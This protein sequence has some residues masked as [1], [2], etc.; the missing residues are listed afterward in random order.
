LYEQLLRFSPQ[1]PLIL[2]SLSEVYATRATATGSPQ[3]S[4][5]A[6]DIARELYAKNPGNTMAIQCYAFRLFEI[7]N[8]KEAENLLAK[9]MVSD[10]ASPRVREIWRLSMENVIEGLEVSGETYR[11]SVLCSQL[12]LYFPQN[13]LALKYLR[14]DGALVPTPAI[15]DSGANDL[16]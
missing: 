12:L 5:K 8:Y 16:F 14:L 6:F 2:A 1:S 11:R 3:D 15:R 7:A 9:F 10:S 13:E 4:A